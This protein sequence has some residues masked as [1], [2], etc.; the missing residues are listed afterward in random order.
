MHV[1]DLHPKHPLLVG[2]LIVML[3]LMAM[4]LAAPDLST[5]EFSTG[6]S[7]V[8]DAPAPVTAD[9]VW[10]SDPLASPVDVLAR[11]GGPG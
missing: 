1:S 4:L 9:P 10:P 6:G 7:S 5:L 8:V 11:P 2:A 3:A